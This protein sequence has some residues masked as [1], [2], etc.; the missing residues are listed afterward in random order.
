MIPVL[1]ARI[2][3]TLLAAGD[4]DGIIHLFSLS[5]AISIHR[6]PSEPLVF[7]NDGLPLVKSSGACG[8]ISAA[9]LSLIVKLID[10]VKYRLVFKL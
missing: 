7:R 6:S 10:R 2:D 8:S 9:C 5:F 3:I 1:D 4:A